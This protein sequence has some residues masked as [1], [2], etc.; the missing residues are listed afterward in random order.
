MTAQED[1]LDG[2]TPEIDARGPVDGEG[3]NQSEHEDPGNSHSDTDTDELKSGE[4]RTDFSD[5]DDDG[6]DAEN[7]SE[8][9]LSLFVSPSPT[10]A[11]AAEGAE[12][13]AEA[14]GSPNQAAERKKRSPRTAGLSPAG[15]KKFKKRFS[16]PKGTLFNTPAAKYAEYENAMQHQYKR[17]EP[18][19]SR[20]IGIVCRVPCTKHFMIYDWGEARRHYKMD[21]EGNFKHPGQP[22][23]NNQFKTMSKSNAAKRAKRVQKDEKPYDHAS[24]SESDVHDSD[25]GRF[26]SIPGRPGVIP[27][28]ILKTRKPKKGMENA[29]AD[30]DA[31][32]GKSLGKKEAKGGKSSDTKEDGKDPEM[33]QG[34][35]LEAHDEIASLVAIITVDRQQRSQEI[36]DLYNEGVLNEQRAA[37]SLLHASVYQNRSNKIFRR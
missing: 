32:E 16:V 14:G 15:K 9:E 8:P 7:V 34:D 35:L 12:A 23:D 11:V 10:L 13:G 33:L 37:V 22:F 30:G 36:I 21:E 1:N 25:Y 19:G 18:K 31:K 6:E 24:E 27:E 29:P 5:D 28:K 20:R 26:N 2:V 17:K 3:Q 4:E